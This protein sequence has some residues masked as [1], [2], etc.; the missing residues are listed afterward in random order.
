MGGVVAVA[1]VGVGVYFG[2]TNAAAAA[3]TAA[4]T[5]TAPA[6]AMPAAAIATHGV[7]VNVRIP[8][9]I[10]LPRHTLLLNSQPRNTE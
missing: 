9:D 3:A 4:A 1:L 5:A 2:I 10:M 6:A 8:Q 7:F